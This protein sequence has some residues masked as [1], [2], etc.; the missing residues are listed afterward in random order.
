MVILK[1]WLYFSLAGSLALAGCGRA[2]APE[3]K[4]NSATT[5]H[6]APEAVSGG[7]VTFRPEMRGL[8]SS[9]EVPLLEQIDRENVRVVNA[10]LPSVVRIVASR[11][12]DPRVK[13]FGNKI[14]FQLPFAPRESSDPD[15]T[16][17]SSGV[18]LSKDGYI[19]TNDHAVSDF[20]VFE[21]QLND[22]RT[23]K[24]KVMAVDEMVDVAILKI[25]ATD[26]TPLPWG[27]SDKVQV[28]QQVF[29]LGNPF[30][31]NDSVSKGIVSAKGR[32]L[33]TP[34]AP[35]IAPYEDYIQTDAAINPGNSGGALIN[36]HGELIGL[37]A[38]IAST[39]RFNMGI[40]FAI[41]S[42]LVRYSVEGLF[43]AGH[44]VR[45]YLGVIL[46]D[47]V[48]DGVENGLNLKSSQ[49]ALL[50]DI[51]PQSPADKAK[52]HPFDF[53]TA[54]NNHKI[55]SEADLRLVVAQIPIGK[56]VEVDFV[57]QG[58]P[59]STTVQIAEIP[60]D[61]QDDASEQAPDEAVMTEVKATPAGNVLSGLQVVD[62]DDK[63]RQKFELTDDPIASGVIVNGVE[64]G[65]A[66]DEKGI[67]RG[68]V[69]ESAAINR[70]LAQP[71]T[72]A[73]D[74]AD[75]TGGLKPDEG[76]VLLVHDRER[77]NSFIYLAPPPK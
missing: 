35:E 19:L 33:P 9:D 34:P 41:P 72:A 71:L 67:R 73:K 59:Q 75:L 46:P 39:T 36:I 8:V 66:A 47:S 29:A 11:P 44:P 2:P 28:G 5:Q 13:I 77:G 20:N 12:G 68:D 30:D 76:A 1:R 62:L 52:L 10:A 37:N 21:V 40:G 38:A 25:D 53:I 4:D 58:K 60:R 26:L 69:I 48:D 70:G 27:D 32:N 17:Y 31:L 22:Q 65:S 3:S 54:I 24:A 50:A 16:A 51:Q 64:E 57:R 63:N 7:P 42:N 74:F 45:G 23:F 6:E 14:P 56:Q 61:D 43:K 49:G 18:I 15:D 55:D